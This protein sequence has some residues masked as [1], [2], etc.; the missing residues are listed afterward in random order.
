MLL[1]TTIKHLRLRP[2]DAT[3]DEGQA[4]E[5]YRLALWSIMTEV[6]SR[7]GGLVLMVM[8]IRWA[9]PYLGPERFGV[10]A[11]FVSLPLLLAFLDLGVANAMTNRV[12][13]A[14]RSGGPEAAKTRIS[15]GL[16]I[17]TCIAI[18]Q[19][20]ALFCAATIMPWG[21][22]LKLQDASLETEVRTAAQVLAASSALILISNGLGRVLHGLQRAYM[23]HIAHTIGSVCAL[24]ALY[25]A[26]NRRADMATLIACQLLPA[27]LITGALVA[28][29]R[30]NGLISTA[31][32]MSALKA[33]GPLLIR[34]GALFLVLQ[35]GTTI[36]W[37][38]DS[39]I[40]ATT[41]GAASVAAF[42]V[43]ARLFQLIS[44]PLS[45]INSPLWAAYADAHAAGDTR[46]IRLTFRYSILTTFVI[47]SV[48]AA[49]C[50][51]FGDT[52]IQAWTSN[53]ITTT[54][55]LLAALAV[56]A[57]LECCGNSLSMLLNGL[58]II[59]QQVITAVFFII[60]AIPIKI[61]LTSLFGGVGLVFGSIISYVAALSIGYGILF[62][63]EI[64]SAIQGKPSKNPS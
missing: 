20:V 18:A 11:T 33:E 62:R 13:H 44:Q 58:N 2:F 24:A 35:M 56:W 21:S 36:G 51:A 12:A 53:S 60:L 64:L 42:T 61:M 27:T 38:A 1:K 34:S 31:R 48:G 25:I 40:L 19:G 3:T 14:M 4:A 29:L 7:I 30:R 17:L 54:H 22:I 50:V 59:R 57:I 5:R 47:S 15:S 16:L 43:S 26:I 55:Q 8:S 41:A 52:V 32:A 10:W 37:G 49:F 46:F 63:S 45:V 28:T 6:L 23:V 39:A 9:A